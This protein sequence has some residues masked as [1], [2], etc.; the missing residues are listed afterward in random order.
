MPLRMLSPDNYRKLLEAFRAGRNITQAA[1][2]A[3]VDRETARKA[4]RRGMMFK[5]PATGKLTYRDPIEEMLEKERLAEHEKITKEA[6][7]RAQIE[8]RA[9]VL[10]REE[11]LKIKD[12]TG[13]LLV[14]GQSVL[15]N[16]ASAFSRLSRGAAEI[17]KTLVDENGMPTA[18]MKKLTVPQ[19]V[20]LLTQIASGARHWTAALHEWQR[21]SRLHHGEPEALV[22]LMAV[23]NESPEEMVEAVRASA[24]SVER[25]AKTLQAGGVVELL[26]EKEEEPDGEA[27]P[28]GAAH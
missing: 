13:K 18:D 25:Y 5:D 4:Y 28:N 14:G 24:A 3:G 6:E 9:K 23:E 2:A 1:K 21:A 19:R 22:G 8:E 7:E 11:A 15:A 26:S 12:A 20:Q 17:M 16:T 10:A 27:G